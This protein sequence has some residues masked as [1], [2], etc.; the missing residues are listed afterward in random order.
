MKDKSITQLRTI[1]QGLGVSDVF[2]LSRAHLIQG[3]EAKHKELIPPAPIVIPAPVY[4]V[5]LMTAAPAQMCDKDTLRQMLE[6]YIKRGLNVEI[7]DETWK[8]RFGKKM[9]TGT[10][11][12][13]LRIALKK[14]AE[15]LS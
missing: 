12:M 6:P 14:A 4:D 11:R 13:P 3:I 2:A 10:L 8:F 5:R 7:G 1:A 9:D 15:V